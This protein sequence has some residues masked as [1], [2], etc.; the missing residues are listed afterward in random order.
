MSG[1]ARIDDRVYPPLTAAQRAELRRLEGV[2]EDE[3][4]GLTSHDWRR[5]AVRLV[6]GGRVPIPVTT[7]SA[8]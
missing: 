5:P 6:R 1:I 2:V 7:G 8:A 4:A 3:P